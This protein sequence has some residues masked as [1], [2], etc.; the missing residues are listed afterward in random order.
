[1]ESIFFSKN[2]FNIFSIVLSMKKFSFLF[3]FLIFI[4]AI[5]AVA[6]EEVGNPKTQIDLIFNVTDFGDHVEVT[7]KFPLNAQG[8][9]N[10]TINNEK[11][12][13]KVVNGEAKLNI[14]GL[15]PGVYVIKANYSGDDNYMGIENQTKIIINA[16]KNS[17]DNS[18]NTVGGDGNKTSGK[19]NS[20]AQNN[21]PSQN[22]T[23]VIVVVNQT[24]NKTP[25]QNNTT[26]DNVTTTVDNPYHPP[27]K[28]PNNQPFKIDAKTGIP[29]ILVI[30]AAAILIAVRKYEF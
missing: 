26:S 23:T 30:I 2:L 19:N 18:T 16:S 21:Q 13:V 28:E 12:E 8:V 17:T 20:P 1:M 25:T 9:V 6:S 11:H 5:S 27:K 29:I 22:N 24:Q 3:I 14:S 4:L 10:Y 15:N 7:I